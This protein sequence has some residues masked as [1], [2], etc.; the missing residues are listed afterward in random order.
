MNWADIEDDEVPTRGGGRSLGERW[1]DVSEDEDGGIPRQGLTTTSTFGGNNTRTETGYG[2]RDGKAIK[3]VKVYK[4]KRVVR[5][6][7]DAIR[8]RKLW[9]MFGKCKDKE[10]QEE[11]GK[12]TPIQAEEEVRMEMNK[13]KQLKSSGA[14]EKFW[15]QCIQVVEQLMQE[16]TKKKY[17]ANEARRRRDAEEAAAALGPTKGSWGPGK[18]GSGVPS[19]APGRYVPPSM[20]SEAGGKGGQDDR[21]QEN[22]LRVTNLSEEAR[23]GDVQNLFSCCGS[24]TRVFM[25]RHRDGEKMDQHKGFAFVQFRD[26][27]DAERAVKRLHGYGYDSLILNVTFAQAKPE[28]GK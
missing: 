17:D 9:A 4:Q 11:F 20:R 21:R 15:E 13:E 19:G 28:G 25:P 12:N 5:R 27:A 24:V 22:T 6:L 3:I 18:G 1:A 10:F 7:N 16:S 14:E 8:E 23:E 26:R 2:E